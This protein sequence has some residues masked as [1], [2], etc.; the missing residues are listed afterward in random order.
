MFIFRYG[1][2]SMHIMKSC[3]NAYNVAMSLTKNSIYKHQFDKKLLALVE[4]GLSQH[5]LNIENDKLAKLDEA[6]TTKIIVE[7]LN[8]DAVHAIIVIFLICLG[9]CIVTFFLEVFCGLVIFKN[10]QEIQPK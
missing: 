1:E 4:S 6:S 9:L 7:P 8:F 3:P 10:D 5:Y 2:T